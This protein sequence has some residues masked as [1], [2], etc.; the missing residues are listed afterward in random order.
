MYGEIAVFAFAL[1][2][3]AVVVVWRRVRRAGA[4]PLVSERF[5]IPHALGAS[6]GLAKIRIRRCSIPLLF[7]LGTFSLAVSVGGTFFFP[8]AWE[9]LVPVQSEIARAAIW[10]GIWMVPLLG[11]VALLELAERRAVTSA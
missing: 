9:S 8:Q 10:L 2:I 1:V 11:G 6:P 5:W 3:L 4:I 7:F